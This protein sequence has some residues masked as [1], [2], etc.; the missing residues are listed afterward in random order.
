MKNQNG[1][2][3]LKLRHLRIKIIKRLATKGIHVSLFN[4]LMRELPF[5][6][7]WS[8]SRRLGNRWYIRKENIRFLTHTDWAK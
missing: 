7:V 3:I 5:D 2:Q 6:S 4:V 1:V 8:V